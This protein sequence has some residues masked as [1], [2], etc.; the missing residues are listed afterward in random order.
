MAY[1]VSSCLVSCED[2]FIGSFCLQLADLTVSVCHCQ[3]C[4][5]ERKQCFC[6]LHAYAM[7]TK[8]FDKVNKLKLEGEYYVSCLI[9]V[10]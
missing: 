4:E 9:G 6:T 2:I 10:D 7:N 8:E 3:L 5:C 1:E